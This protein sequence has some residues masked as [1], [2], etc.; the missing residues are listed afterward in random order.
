MIRRPA[1][2]LFYNYN[3]NSCREKQIAIWQVVTEYLCK[4][5][6]A[7]G[8]ENAGF[9]HWLAAYLWFPSFKF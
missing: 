8:T 2:F 1:A 7:L 4:V 5:V 9:Q 6:A 3:G